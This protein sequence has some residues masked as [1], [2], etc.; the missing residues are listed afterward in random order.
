M[1]QIVSIL[2]VFLLTI[3]SACAQPIQ[4]QLN[5][6]AH[7]SDIFTSNTGKTIITIEADVEIPDVEKISVLNIRPAI[8]TVGDVRA[9]AEAC[10]TVPYSEIP[11]SLERYQTPDP[12][13]P[14]VALHDLQ[15]R[16]QEVNADGLR[17]NLFYTQRFQV[18]GTPREGM[19]EFTNAAHY[20]GYHTGG[21]IP[22]AS[23][24]AAQARA[25]EIAHHIAPEFELAYADR[26]CNMRDGMM[27]GSRFIFTRSYGGVPSIYTSKD[28]TTYDNL[29]DTYIRKIP[30]ELLYIIVDDVSGVYVHW[31][32]PHTMIGVETESTALLSFGEIM[33]IAESIL[34]LKYAHQEKYL[35]ARRQDAYRLTVNRITLGYTRIQSRDDPEQ[36]LFVPVWDFFDA[37]DPQTSLLTINAVDGT[38]IHRG[39]GY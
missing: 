23:S 33:D 12:K 27:S 20:Y 32:S 38:V 9:V 1:K 15:I 6:P 2:L 39:Y 4:E 5:A 35:E 11:D 28:C 31:R 8:F 36:Y 7:V 21:E 29:A 30:Y 26:T 14:D 3:C 19:I 22:G 16:Q 25:L 13:V 24:E 17:E 10:F 18:D 37:E 34:P